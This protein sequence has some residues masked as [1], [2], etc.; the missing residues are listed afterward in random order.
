MGAGPQSR[1]TAACLR[2]AVALVA[3]ADSDLRRLDAH[4]AE[5]AL[6]LE[7]TVIN[8]PVAGL[9]VR[10]SAEIGD[11]L[12]PGAILAALAQEGTSEL[13]AEIPERYLAG[14]AVGQAATCRIG[15]IE[16][17]LTVRRNDGVTDTRSRTG[18]VRMASREA[19]PAVMG[20]VVVGR[21]PVA[22]VSGLRLPLSA[23]RRLDPALVMVVR[24]GMIAAQ[25]VEVVFSDGEIAIIAG[26]LGTDAL[27]VAKAPGLVEEGQSVRTVMADAR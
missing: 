1:S 21:I 23:L 11:L 27:V 7:R 2:A 12:A 14:I 13:A 5:L 15:E 3:A 24:A 25:P 9:V 17:A 6:A 4:L 20:A 16:V 26:G 19:L 22:T 8:A 10:R 18:I